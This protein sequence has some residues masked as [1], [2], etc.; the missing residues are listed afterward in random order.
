MSLP[1]AKQ[2]HGRLLQNER[3]KRGYHIWELFICKTFHMS[4]QKQLELPNITRDLTVSGCMWA[5]VCVRARARESRNHT[6]PGLCAIKPVIKALTAQNQASNFS[7]QGPH[8]Q[9]T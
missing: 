9:P 6:S 5:C 2:S 4:I 3:E 8:V 1:H 7:L